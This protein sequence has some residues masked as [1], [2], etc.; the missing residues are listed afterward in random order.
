MEEEQ[1]AA[2]EAAIAKARENGEKFVFKDKMKIKI[3]IAEKWSEKTPNGRFRLNEKKNNKVVNRAK[4]EAIE[5][6]N[7]RNRRRPKIQSVNS[8]DAEDLDLFD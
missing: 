8:N 3:E 6:G 4:R 2:I 5:S 1:T 7:W